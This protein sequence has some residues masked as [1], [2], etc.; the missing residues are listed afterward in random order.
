MNLHVSSSVLCLDNNIMD[1][2]I[3]IGFVMTILAKCAWHV[4]W[5]ACFIKMLWKTRRKRTAQV[6][7]YAFNIINISCYRI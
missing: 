5:R 3:Y 2:A 4:Q 1:M 7:S 6:D